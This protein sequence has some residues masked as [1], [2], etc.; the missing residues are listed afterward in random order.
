ML[1]MESISF[2]SKPVATLFTWVW[3]CWI[4]L[5]CSMMVWFRD[6]T[7]CS[8]CVKSDS[9]FTSRS[10]CDMAK[11]YRKR[12]GESIAEPGQFLTRSYFP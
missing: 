2:V 5:S 7:S 4:V 10:S 11:G 6:D 12:G 9:I 3:S 8:K 1:L